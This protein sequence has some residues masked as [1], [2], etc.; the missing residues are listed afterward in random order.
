[1]KKGMKDVR[2]ARKA[3]R[4]YG[5]QA[6]RCIVCGRWH[7]RRDK[8]CSSACTRRPPGGPRKPADCDR[9]YNEIRRALHLVTGG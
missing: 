3:E 7:T 1:M 2:G 4:Q 6:K 8:T 5:D 9:H